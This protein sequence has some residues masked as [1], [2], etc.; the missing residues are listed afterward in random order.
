MGRRI[1]H[2]LNFFRS[3]P[4][5]RFD[6]FHRLNPHVY[7][8]LR[9]LCH[10]VRRAGVARFG[11]RTVWERLRWKARFETTRPASDYRLN[12]HYTPFYARLLMQEPELAGL[13]ETRE[14]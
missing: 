5:A 13:F 3:T 10:Q 1:S 9:D 7:S 4:E 8:D 2:Q 11:I 6:D 12:D 14:R